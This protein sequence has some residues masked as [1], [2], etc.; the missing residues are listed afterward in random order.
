MC[1][2]SGLTGRMNSLDQRTTG[3]TT[4]AKEASLLRFVLQIDL[5]QCAD[6]WIAVLIDHANAAHRIEHSLP[7]QPLAQHTTLLNV[8]MTQRESRVHC[9]FPLNPFRRDRHSL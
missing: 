3:A 1:F 8:G 2:D 6:L 4:H 5:E 7:A 9:V